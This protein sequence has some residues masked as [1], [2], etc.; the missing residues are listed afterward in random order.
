MA[1]LSGHFTPDFIAAAAAGLYRN[2]YL[3][4]CVYSIVLILLLADSST[5][6]KFVTSESD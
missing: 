1:S 2:N 4:Y 6:S 3:Y 5:F